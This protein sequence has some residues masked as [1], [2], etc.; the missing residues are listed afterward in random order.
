MKS[1]YCKLCS[2]RT[3]SDPAAFTWLCAALPL[4]AHIET[5]LTP[6]EIHMA[7]WLFNLNIHYISV[8]CCSQKYSKLIYKH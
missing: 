6:Q 2:R 4:K 5:F 7:N 1:K 3:T 8:Y